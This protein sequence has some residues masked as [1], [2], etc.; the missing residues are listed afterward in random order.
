MVFERVHGNNKSNKD[1]SGKLS[2]HKTKKEDSNL[3]R[4]RSIEELHDEDDQQVSNLASPQLERPKKK[5]RETTT[6][7]RGIETAVTENSSS[8]SP[9]MQPSHVVNVSSKTQPVK[10]SGSPLIQSTTPPEGKPNAPVAE[11]SATNTMRAKRAINE[12]DDDAPEDAPSSK[13][14]KIR[15]RA[16]APKKIT[17]KLATTKKATSKVL[18]SVKDIEGGSKSS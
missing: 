2:K 12:V 10:S 4:K 16:K 17:T 6:P 14:A 8:S 18:R 15:S 3:K 13:K 1:K 5:Q 9:D 11:Q 7:L